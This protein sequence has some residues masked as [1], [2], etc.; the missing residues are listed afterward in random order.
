MNSIL[1]ETLKN[2]YDRLKSKF[3]KKMSSLKLDC[4]SL[5]FSSASSLT[6]SGNVLSFQ[7]ASDLLP[8]FEERV[9]KRIILSPGTNMKL[10][11]DISTAIQD[12]LD[13]NANYD[14]TLSNVSYDSNTSTY[15]LTI[16]TD[17]DLTELISYMSS[18]FII[19]GDAVEHMRFDTINYG[20]ANNVNVG[21]CI[22]FDSSK[23]HLHISNNT[24]TY[25]YFC[26]ISADI[27]DSNGNSNVS[28]NDEIILSGYNFQYQ[29]IDS[30]DTALAINYDSI[31]GY[32]GKFLKSWY[33]ATANQSGSRT[34][35][36]PSSHHAFYY[37][38][39]WYLM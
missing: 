33:F 36:I 37:D 11:D 23:Q 9:G 35:D 18:V 24:T 29:T 15:S 22:L 5:S 32:G 17:G 14:M 27:V 28:E 31:K 21:I 6:V 13:W 3:D 19:V 25:A 4:F 10:T 34:K 38:T 20:A 2:F 7:Q 16:T 1:K 30:G 26:V 8:Y 12:F 39:T